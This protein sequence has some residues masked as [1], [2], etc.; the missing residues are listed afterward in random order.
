MGIPVL[1][2]GRS[3]TGKST[4]L[5]NFASEEVAVINIMGKPLPFRST[6][7][8][9]VTQD[10]GKVKNALAKAKRDSIVI[11][12]AGYL[13]TDMFMKGHSAAAKGGDVFAFYN[14][15]GDTFYHLMRFVVNA[16]EPHRIVYFIMHEDEDDHGNLKPK[17][18]GKLLDGKVCLEGLVSILLRSVHSNDKYMFLTNG[19]GIQKS[20]IDM[21]E[22]DAIDNDLKLVDDTIRE[23]WN[24][25]K[26][27]EKENGETA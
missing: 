16:L 25:P 9:F 14:E 17:T 11:D 1:I 21:F 3:G 19:N 2:I 22:T 23:Y 5:R 24:L 4:S 18:I 6:I 12:D 27:E 8:T 7:D 26:Q 10:Y 20:P 13:I 15:V